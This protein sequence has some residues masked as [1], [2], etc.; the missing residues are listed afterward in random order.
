VTPYPIHPQ[1]DWLAELRQTPMGRCLL[2]GRLVAT[3]VSPVDG[4][5]ITVRFSAKRPPDRA[6]GESRWRVCD[7][8]E[9]TKVFVD[10]PGQDLAAGDKVGAL[11]VRRGVF[12]ADNVDQRRVNAARYVLLSA[13]GRLPGEK[14]QMSVACL[15]C[16]KP[17]T[18]PVSIARNIGPVCFGKTTRSRHEV[19]GDDDF[20]GRPAPPP[21]P[22]SAVPAPASA[23]EPEAP[24]D[25]PQ[26]VLVDAGADPRHQL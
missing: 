5:H 20:V 7:L 18:D 4:R 17:L 25:G 9:A 10:V 19:K 16:G 23:P 22:L 24:S 6:A 11:D 13:L 15:F 12:F 1:P 21:P 8:L 14:V 26:F 3:A 2:A